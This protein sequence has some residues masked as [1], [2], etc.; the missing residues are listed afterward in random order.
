MIQLIND[1]KEKE[2]YLQQYGV[3]AADSKLIQCN[4][5]IVGMIDYT[6]YKDS[7]KIYYIT[8]ENKYRR[9]GIAKQVIDLIGN[10]N[11]GKYIYGDA[12]PD[13]L[14]FWSSMGAE[15][16]E[17]PDEDYLTPFHILY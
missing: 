14:K 2:K 11:Q 13:A 5:T 12:V 16:D 3:I 7:V 4:G 8:I 6:E 9:Q 17:D 1:C 15:F 10:N